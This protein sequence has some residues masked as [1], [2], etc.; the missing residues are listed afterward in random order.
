MSRGAAA[1]DIRKILVRLA[2][3]GT[4]IVPDNIAGRHGVVREQRQ[5]PGVSVARGEI[6]VELLHHL[7][8]EGLVEKA[9]PAGWRVSQA[10]K[11]WLR[12]ALSA[13]DA[14]QTQHRTLAQRKF[15]KDGKFQQLTVNLAE[16]PLAWLRRRKDETGSPFLSDAQF[17]AGERLRADYTRGNLLPSIGQRWSPVMD[18]G[19]RRNGGAGGQADLLDSSIAARD[20]VWRALSAVGDEFADVLVDVCCL[21]NGLETVERRKNWPRRSGKVILR[22]GLNSL[23][24]HY[25]LIVRARSAGAG[26][27]RHWGEADYRPRAMD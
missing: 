19:A 8:S 11:A 18:S 25:G 9:A 21:L 22:L 24:R 3:P 12:R 6:T 16:S 13:G 2:V 10:G 14:F 4:R 26:R 7:L 1:P 23:A 15:E 17:S 20:R 5:P 27:M